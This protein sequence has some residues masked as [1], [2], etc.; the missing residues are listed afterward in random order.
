MQFL[1]IYLFLTKRSSSKTKHYISA[2]RRRDYTI[3]S[4]YFYFY[5]LFNPSAFLMSRTINENNDLNATT[6]L[7]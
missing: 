5:S 7:Y 2:G 3:T 1:F 6:Y 4:N